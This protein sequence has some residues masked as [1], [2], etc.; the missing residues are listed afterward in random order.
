MDRTDADEVEVVSEADY[1][2]ERVQS[3]RRFTVREA[4]V[5]APY[6]PLLLLWMIGRVAAGQAAEVSFKDAELDLKLLMHCYWGLRGASDL[7][8][9]SFGC[10]QGTQHGDYFGFSLIS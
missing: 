9:N 3:I 10:V 6:K 2:V 7:R 4:D 8:S 1:W 5:R